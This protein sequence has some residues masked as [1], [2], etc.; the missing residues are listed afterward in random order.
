MTK[1]TANL[2]ERLYLVINGAR[3]IGA[4]ARFSITAQDNLR[5]DRTDLQ[6]RD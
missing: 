3:K 4:G 6:R 2:P 1:Y 5:C